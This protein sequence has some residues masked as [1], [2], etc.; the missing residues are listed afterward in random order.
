[1]IGP[2]P[3]GYTTTKTEK[4]EALRRVE[5]RLAL[6]WC[7]GAH[8]LSATGHSTDLWGSRA[9]KWCL[10]GAIHVETAHCALSYLC[11][12]KLMDRHSGI[13]AFNDAQKI[14]WPVIAFVA[15]AAQNLEREIAA[16]AVD[17]AKQPRY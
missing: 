13:E 5:K 2:Q 11:G 1:M 7:R 9:V 15:S 3:L 16:V 6:G 4:A 17:S 8:A 14:A 12:D 10:A